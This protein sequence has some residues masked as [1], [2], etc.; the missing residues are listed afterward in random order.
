MGAEAP[1]FPACAVRKTKNQS[2]VLEWAACL[3]KG[4][5]RRY[6]VSAWVLPKR[7]SGSTP[8][9]VGV[10]PEHAPMVHATGSSC[11]ARL[12]PSKG[13]PR[14]GRR[15]PVPVAKRFADVLWQRDDINY[16]PASRWRGS[17]AW[18]TPL[19]GSTR[20]SPELIPSG[21]AWGS[22]KAWCH[23]PEPRGL[24]I[25]CVATRRNLFH[26]LC[27]TFPCLGAMFYG[28]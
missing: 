27:S 13:R 15:A 19:E 17:P 14:T 9:L 24:Y 16:W 5:I 28:N 20:K 26:D 12:P 2:R 18:P 10:F 6:D 4:R 7:V 23:L 8:V 22:Q 11:V 3:Q 25:G 21:R 1:P